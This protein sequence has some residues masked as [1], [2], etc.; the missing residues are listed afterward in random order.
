MILVVY[1]IMIKS[2][3]F[4]IFLFLVIFLISSI[5]VLAD[6]DKLRIIVIGAHP[7]D[8]EAVGAT[9]IKFVEAGHKVRMVSMTNGNAGHFSEGGGPLAWRRYQETRCSSAVSGVEYI[10][11]DIDDGK[12]MPTLENRNKVIAQIREFEADIV[13]SHRTNDYHPDHRNAA[14]LVRDAAYMVTVPNIVPSVPHLRKNPVF[15]YM[16]DRFTIPN[17]FKPDIVVDTTDLIDRKLD[18]WD[19]HV[20]Q[21]YEWI[22]YNMNMLDQVPEDPADRKAWLAEWWGPFMN[23]PVAEYRDKLIELYG[24]ERAAEVKAVEAFQVSEYGVQP[25]L[26]TLKQMFPFFP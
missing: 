7:D 10:V 8:P 18:M 26:E 2:K 5:M 12:L 16:Y 11:M 25:D 4:T 6:S 3:K 22:P 21:M 20:S 17:P 19:C 14:L 9:M 15:M 1:L 23:G 24:A 13:V